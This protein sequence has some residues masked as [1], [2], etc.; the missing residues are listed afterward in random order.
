MTEI[1]LKLRVPSPP[2]FIDVD[3]AVGYATYDEPPNPAVVYV[4]ELSD[5]Q[6]DSLALEWA[7]AIKALARERRRNK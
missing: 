1:T 2:R 3:K 4:E 5:E 6:I 7:G